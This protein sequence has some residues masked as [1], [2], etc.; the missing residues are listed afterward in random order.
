MIVLP[1]QAAPERRWLAHL[2]RIG[3]GALR[4]GDLFDDAFPFDDQRIVQL[5]MRHRVAPLLHTALERG[6]VA[7][8]VPESFR[9][10]C[11]ETYFATLR[12]NVVALEIGEAALASLRAAGIPVAPVKGFHLLGPDGV[13]DDPGVRPMDDLDLMVARSDIDAAGEIL[14]SLGFSLVTGR[15][16]ARL[17]AGHELA[18]H[19]PIGRVNLFIELHWA[20][21]GPESLMRAHAVSAEDFLRDW[22]EV[23]PAGSVPGRVGHLLFVA[24]HAARHAFNRWI[25]LVDLHRIVTDGDAVDW[26]ELLA[27]ARSLRVRRPLYAGL[28]AARELLRTPVPKE[29]LARLAPGRVRRQLLHRTLAGQDDAQSALTRGRVAKVL[30]GESWWDVAR[31]AAW[32]AS[33][34]RAWHEDRATDAPATQRRGASA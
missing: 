30:L 4:P 19:R 22:C 32:A 29:V 2:V 14:S 3:A 17:A 9:D 7:D 12:K 6:D 1:A 21:A 25:W 5:A 26:E 11:R 28:A 20:W 24:V 15:R 18:Y 33:P 23:G 10:L 13:Y 8:T 16:Q 27:A 31:T 34:G